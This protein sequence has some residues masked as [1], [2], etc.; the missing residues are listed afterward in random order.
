MAPAH[1][2]A[3]RESRDRMNATLP[4]LALLLDIDGTLVDFAPHPDE[5][6]IA[7]DLVELLRTLNDRLGGALALVSGRPIS[8]IDRLVA[9]L[10]L[11]AIGLHGA[12]IRSHAWE[13]AQMR[14]PVRSMPDPL[15]MAILA[16]ALQYPVFFED[17]EGL[18][19]A[20]HYDPATSSSE[21]LRR[22]LEAMLAPFADAWTL[23]AGRHVYEVK[24]LGIDKGSACRLLVAQPPFAGRKTV[25]IGDDVTDLDAFAAIDELGGLTVSVGTRVAHAAELALPDPEGAVAWLRRLV[26]WLDGAGP[27]PSERLVG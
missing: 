1:R 2:P 22:A 24:P 15:R 25:Y 5:V 17:K 16:T 26:D 14:A 11:T 21:D 13:A 7:P 20:V 27:P 23:L 3:L 8:S 6:R 4:R 19:L 12:Q 18:A 9:P 10:A